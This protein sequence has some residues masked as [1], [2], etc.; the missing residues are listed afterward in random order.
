M[1]K[2]LISLATILLVFGGIFAGKWYTDQQA[3]GANEQTG[4]AVSVA[5]TAA[6]DAAWP[7]R[8]R[9]IATLRAVSGIEITAQIAGNATEIAFESGARVHKGDLLVQ[10]DNSS[11]LATLHADQAKLK[12]ASASLTRTRK[13]ISS[14]AT[15]KAKLQAAQMDHAV[16]VAA[17]EHDKSVL[18]KLR[19]VAPFDGVLGIREIS[20]GEYVS[21]G[22]NIV[23]L[24]RLDPMLLDFALPQ[25]HLSQIKVSQDVVFTT[26]AWPK[27][28][29]NG[30]ITAIGA[31]IDPNTRNISVQATLAN[32]DKQL[33]PGLFGHVKLELG[34]TMTGVVVPQTAVAYSTF[35]DTVYVVTDDEQAG[36]TAHAKV[37][38][39]LDQRDGQSLLKADNINVGDTVVTAGQ[40]K[41]YD[42]AAVR[43][44]NS[45]QP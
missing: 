39:V 3:D 25:E 4:Y 28:S 8:I 45:V 23:N 7:S 38:H 24:Q 36:K 40:N 26:N 5:T 9:A 13:L 18:A 33:R 44:D 34:Q 27:R 2:W 35:G 37:V 31:Q 11:Q 43:I 19:I 41:L 6:Q 21:P 22:T 15:S 16:A 29:F 17:V 12:Q 20:L 10:L 30:K 14:Q 32:A 1:T 42:G